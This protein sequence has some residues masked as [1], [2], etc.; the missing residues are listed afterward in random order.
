MDVKQFYISVNGNYQ[1]ALSIMMN[2]ALIVRMI[3]KFMGNNSCLD[4]VKAYENKDFQNLFVL[5]HTLKGV[6]GNLAITPLFEIASII[7]EA[8]RNGT[9]PN[10]DNE[11]KQLKDIYANLEDSFHEY[12][13]N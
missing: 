5:S 11:I 2:D 13:E 12:I 4:M 10:L 6:V 7:T 1:A 3:T 8:T 9:T